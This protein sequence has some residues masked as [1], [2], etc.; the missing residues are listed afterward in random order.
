ME[1]I[2]VLRHIRQFDHKTVLTCC[3]DSVRSRI[4]SLSIKI[5]KTAGAGVKMYH[6]VRI[7]ATIAE[8]TS[9]P[10]FA[11]FHFLE[12]YFDCNVKIDANLELCS[13]YLTF[14]KELLQQAS[15][16]KTLFPS[17]LR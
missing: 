5:K 1:A 14:M 12:T 4:P 11:F 10:D 16:Y 6:R 3:L 7:A 9:R 17:A 13:I 15:L 8:T 2:K